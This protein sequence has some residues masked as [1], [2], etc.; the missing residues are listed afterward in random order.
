MSTIKMR[1]MDVSEFQSAIHFK[2]AKKAGME[3][4]IARAGYG[5]AIKYP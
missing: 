5:S 2:N 4:A 3:F 1:G